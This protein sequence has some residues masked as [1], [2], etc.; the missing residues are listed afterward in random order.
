MDD[1]PPGSSDALFRD[2]LGI[3]RPGEAP[4]E[5]P[6]THAFG[7]ALPP[8][9]PPHQNINPSSGGGV[10]FDPHHFPRGGAQE[11]H[12]EEGILGFS[13][14]SEL[15]RGG[16]WGGAGRRSV[17]L[18]SIL[19]DAEQVRAPSISPHVLGATSAE[20]GV[21]SWDCSID[22]IDCMHAREETAATAGSPGW[23]ALVPGPS[24]SASLSQSRKSVSSSEG[25]RHRRDASA[26]YSKPARLGKDASASDGEAQVAATREKAARENARVLLLPSGAYQRHRLRV[27]AQI[28]KLL[29]EKSPPRDDVSELMNSLS[30]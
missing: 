22:P 16:A 23:S 6:V 26:P 5:L 24:W 12:E 14:V 18:A 29:D 3:E 2:A 15:A 11:Q 19:E 20:P 10:T 9:L 8:P 28:F 7:L 27:L 25:R 4:M 13:D 30:L 17:P 21:E 1:I